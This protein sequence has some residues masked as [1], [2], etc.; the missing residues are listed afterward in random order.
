MGWDFDPRTAPADALKLRILYLTDSFGSETDEPRPDSLLHL[1]GKPEASAGLQ[2]LAGVLDAHRAVASAEVMCISN[3]DLL[4]SFEDAPERERTWIWSVLAYETRR[5]SYRRHPYALVVLEQALTMPEHVRLLA[6]L[7]SIADRL[8]LCL[9][10]SAAPDGWAHQRLESV[11]AS[12]A[13]RS[14]LPCVDP[15]ALAAEAV[16]TFARTGWCVEASGAPSFDA[17]HPAAYTLLLQQLARTLRYEA[18]HARRADDDG[19]M[20]SVEAW[21]AN[22]VVG[23]S[24]FVEAHA[25]WASPTELALHVVVRSSAG[26][27]APMHT[28]IDLLG[29]RS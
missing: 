27:L 22:H 16:T 5:F 9:I 24:P 12:R 3:Y 17:G 8:Q 23:C 11:R 15:A 2:R 14:V 21:L 19:M 7:A 28:T 4:S 6:D 26:A 25:Q 20:H 18:V 13:A 10:A 1:A 29:A